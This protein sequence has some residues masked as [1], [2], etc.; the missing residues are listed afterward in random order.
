LVRREF[1]KAV[2]YETVQVCVI[3]KGAVIGEELLLG[4]GKYYYNVRVRSNKALCF[5]MLK[6]S[7]LPEFQ[8]LQIYPYLMK[9]Y[10]QKKYF[11]IQP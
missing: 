11:A 8:L 2:W 7:N 4:N 1:E 9:K 10:R 3:Q 6:T 5:T